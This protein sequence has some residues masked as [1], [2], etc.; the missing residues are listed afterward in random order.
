MRGK[1]GDFIEWR[2][3]RAYVQVRIP[4]DA[5]AAFNGKS[6]FSKALNTQHA[7][8]A[9]DRA[10]PYIVAVK[11]QIAEFRAQS[12]V[13]RAGVA[14]MN[15]VANTSAAADKFS[16]GDEVDYAAFDA[17]CR[18]SE[19][20]F[21]RQRT[22]LAAAGIDEEFYLAIERKRFELGV[23]REYPQPVTL[24]DAAAALS[25]E[26]RDALR[27]GLEQ[28]WRDAVAEF[29][30]EVLADEAKLRQAGI[31]A[32]FLP[33]PAPLPSAGATPRISEAIETFL[34]E[35]SIKNKSGSFSPETRDKH[36]QRLALFAEHCEDCPVGDLTPQ[37]VESF[38]A[39]LRKAVDVS[40]LPGKRIKRTLA[41]RL[42]IR[43]ADPSLAT[44]GTASVAKHY[45]AVAPFLKFCWRRRWLERQIC[46]DVRDKPRHTPSK[47][48][49]VLAYTAEQ[50]QMIFDALPQCDP[51]MHWHGLLMMFSGC[52]PEESA[53]L[54]CNDI[55]QLHGVWVIDINEL[56][57][58]TVKTPAGVRRVPVH[59][60]LIKMGILD[61]VHTRPQAARLFPTFKRP[62]RK[63]GEEGRYL[64]INV[65]KRIGRMVR[66]LG[67][68][69]ERI[70]PQYSLRHRFHD[71]MDNAGVP[72]SIQVQLVGHEEE[73][74]I[75]GGY[76][77]GA[78]LKVLADW[79]GKVDP[80]A[81]A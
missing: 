59:P 68:T 34:A 31:V 30:A 44:A 46:S 15:G 11:R 5:R 9:R 4:E 69:D 81:H 21:A 32:P 19:R 60:R 26:D 76:G 17:L 49:E 13:Q 27:R 63:N 45:D 79:M 16:V 28:R 48:E 51:D 6:R 77:Q 47:S 35:G 39:A 14:F 25:E 24:P 74:R 73:N 70:Q 41:D 72:Q 55:K 1:T 71:A 57:D 50:S 42:A 65:G 36:R 80:L 54:M 3:G 52:R 56:S 10:R 18:A 29:E 62:R 78:V 43:A 58:G 7:G 38:V 75:H 66:A 8:T 40:K 23:M 2:N 37:H 12:P 64:N 22:M 53:Q 33:P 67:I 20:N 61:F